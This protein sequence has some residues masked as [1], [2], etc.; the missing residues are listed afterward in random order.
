MRGGW[1]IVSDPDIEILQGK[2]VLVVEDEP[3]V[4]MALVDELEDAG[5][6]VIGPAASLEGALDLIAIGGI[7][8][9]I[10]DVELQQKLVYPAAELLMAR[11]VPFILTT[12]HDADVLPK[13][14]AEVPR[15][16]KPAPVTEILQTLARGMRR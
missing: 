6:V 9:A 1:D 10:L 15:S 2:R 16:L 11:G 8:C 3:L 7:D 13:V 14:Y 4:S 5:A 12:G